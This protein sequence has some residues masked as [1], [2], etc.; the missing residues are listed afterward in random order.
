MRADMIVGVSLK[1]WIDVGNNEFV[2]QNWDL[3]QDNALLY[4]RRYLI[5]CIRNSASV[6]TAKSTAIYSCLSHLILLFSSFENILIIDSLSSL[7]SIQD[8]LLTGCTDCL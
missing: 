5:F 8:L 7:L 2:D 6:F 1:D 4:P 3:K